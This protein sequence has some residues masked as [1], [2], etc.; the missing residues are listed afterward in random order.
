MRRYSLRHL[1]DFPIGLRPARWFV[2]IFCAG[3]LFGVGTSV[4]ASGPWRCYQAAINAANATGVPIEVL[5]ALTWT[6]TGRAIDGQT[7]PWPWAVNSGG[8]SH[9]FPDRQAAVEF[10]ALSLRNGTTNL[11]AGCFQINYRW[12]GTNFASIEDMFDPDLNALYAARLIGALHLESNDWSVAAGT[13][14]S[15]TPALATRYRAVFERY[16]SSV[17]STAEPD[18]NPD[19]VGTNSRRRTSRPGNSFLGARVGPV[20]LG[21]LVLL[22]KEG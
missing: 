8:T 22:E 4:S 21:S 20:L 17:R 16:L 19:Q 14:H 12:H 1:G 6:E 10:A 13:Y 18:W 2:A 15:R 5:I 9:W 3:M 11:D 7:Q